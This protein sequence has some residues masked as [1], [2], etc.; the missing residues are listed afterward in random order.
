M[1]PWQVQTLLQMIWE[2]R[3]WA[4]MSNLNLI[5]I[6]DSGCAINQLSAS[7]YEPD[8][9]A[10]KVLTPTTKALQTGNNAMSH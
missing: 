2:Q 5:I 10:N 8:R 9:F 4:V 7:D 6:S 1:G 3:Q